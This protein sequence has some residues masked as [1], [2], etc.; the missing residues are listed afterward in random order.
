MSARSKKRLEDAL[1]AG[2]E[3]ATNGEEPSPREE[4]RL[5]DN[6]NK[7][8]LGDV[9]GV[10]STQI[11]P[12]GTKAA[13]GLG[14]GSIQLYSMEKLDRIRKLLPGSF[15]G[16][17]I[18]SV[19]FYPT[20]IKN[21]LFAAGADASVSIWDMNN[22]THVETIDEPG[23]QIG[24]MDF[25]ND[26]I[27]F[28]TAGKDRNVRLYD[29]ETFK[30]KK[31][32]FGVDLLEV[33]SDEVASSESGHCRKILALRFHPEDKD[34]LLT[35]GW[36]HAVKIW[37]IRTDGVVRTIRG[38][39][40]CGDG[41]DVLGDEILTGS[42]LANNALQVWDYGSGKIIEEIPFPVT[43]HQGQF[44]YCARFWNSQTIVAGGSGS[45]DVKIIERLSKEVIDTLSGENHCVQAMDISQKAQKIIMGTSAN[46]LKSATFNYA[47]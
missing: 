27:T 40:V 22:F 34:I 32:Y 5:I 8:K 12:D 15:I 23:N 45:N 26:G 31:K 7:F 46:I 24:A 16:L 6:I 36:D 44:L 35:A 9:N 18:T 43:D 21:L 37:D 11:S 10:F 13:V 20:T 33:E 14:S 28:A 19:K 41:L 39:F 29:S 30:I 17:P 4:K 1:V 47:H 3:I 42:W 2:R 25:A 38:P